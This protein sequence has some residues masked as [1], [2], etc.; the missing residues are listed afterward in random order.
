[1]CFDIANLSDDCELVIF[2]I[3]VE[4]IFQP[5]LLADFRDLTCQ[6]RDIVLAGC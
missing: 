1:M 3:R 2:A 4:A 6:R 5:W